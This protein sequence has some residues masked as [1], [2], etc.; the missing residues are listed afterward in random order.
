M[1]VCING[2]TLLTI[3]KVY[4]YYIYMIA[5]GRVRSRGGCRKKSTTVSIHLFDTLF[6]DN[7]NKE[8]RSDPQRYTFPTRLVH[9][10]K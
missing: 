2:R 10:N 4:Q 6:I 3:N 9:L 7:N 5:S 1:C 8:H